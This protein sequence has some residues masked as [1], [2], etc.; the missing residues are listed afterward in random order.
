MVESSAAAAVSAAAAE[1]SGPFI[2]YLELVR[3][4]S[5]IPQ[6][7]HA[8]LHNRVISE[9]V[10]NVLESDDPVVHRLFADNPVNV[11]GL[12][13]DDFFGIEGALAQI[14]RYLHSDIREDNQ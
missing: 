7:A 5:S 2:E 3:S 9:G 12:F 11:Y 6:L 4:D 14:A 13:K 10:S 8:R 1:W